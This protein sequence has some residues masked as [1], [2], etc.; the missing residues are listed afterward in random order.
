MRISDW[1]SDVCSS[2]L[3]SGRQVEA[4]GV[5][6][7][8]PGGDK[9]VHELVARVGGGIDLRQGPQLRVRPEHQV[10]AR[11]GPFL[12]IGPSAGDGESAVLGKCVSVRVALGGRGL[13]KKKPIPLSDMFKT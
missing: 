9:V 13:L 8:G 7:L 2:D 6:H 5:H 12:F 11:A 3:S 10:Y 1:S 4:V